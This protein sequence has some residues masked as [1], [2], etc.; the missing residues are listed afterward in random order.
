MIDGG[1]LPSGYLS[2]FPQYD[3]DE[4]LCYL[5]E[6]RKEENGEIEMYV[7]AYRGEP[8]ASRQLIQQWIIEEIDFTLTDFDPNLIGEYVRPRSPGYRW[9][10]GST[11]PARLSWRH[12]DTGRSIGSVFRNPAGLWGNDGIV[13]TSAAALS[14]LQL[15]WDAVHAGLQIETRYV[16][17]NSD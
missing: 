13:V 17:P 8:F 2:A 11:K 10:I 1:E 4:L 9:A 15:Y 16:E 7:E 5:Q 12:P 3:P 6:L 14:C